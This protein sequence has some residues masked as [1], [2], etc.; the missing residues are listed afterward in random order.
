[1]STS[2]TVTN[3]KAFGWRVSQCHLTKGHKYTVSVAADMPKGQVQNLTLFTKGRVVGVNK[4]GVT[5]TLVPVRTAGYTNL[6]LPVVPAGSYEYEAHEESEWW[7]IDY[8]HNRKQLPDA[9]VFSLAAG[10][11]AALPVGTKLLLCAGSVVV[12][13]AQYSAPKVFDL[14][15]GDVVVS[16]EDQC[17]GFTFTKVR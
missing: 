7:C 14:A 4:D 13:G 17:Y 15:S 5:P 11:A 16:A 2:F 10:G 3:H 6:D 8:V 1:M 9:K 12:N